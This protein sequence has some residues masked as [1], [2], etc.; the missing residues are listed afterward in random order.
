MKYHYF[1][2]FLRIRFSGSE[3]INTLR[4]KI[5]NP[6]AMSMTLL[7]WWCLIST[8]WPTY[9]THLDLMGEYS[10][11][12]PKFYVGLELTNRRCTCT[13]GH[14]FPSIFS[15]I[16]GYTT[17]TS[18]HFSGIE[19]YTIRISPSFFGNHTR[20]AG[21]SV[22]ALRAPCVCLCVCV[23]VCVRACVWNNFLKNTKKNYEKENS[24]NPR[25]QLVITVFVGQD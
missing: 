3:L 21:V 12:W 19:G 22:P 15:K 16:E 17:R 23:C 1:Y 13:L 14:F 10:Y 20:I 8:A 11:K 24:L 7:L 4:R 9:I 6:S 18:N 2:R 25:V 5:L